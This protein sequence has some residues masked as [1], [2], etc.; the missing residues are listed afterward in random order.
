[1]E[2]P[3]VGLGDIIWAWS[4]RALSTSSRLPRIASLSNAAPLSLDE[5]TL[6]AIRQWY[7]NYLTT[8]KEVCDV[9]AEGV[10]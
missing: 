8:A 2:A 5:V 10:T 1:M 9:Y 7:L 6:L 4:G 3:H